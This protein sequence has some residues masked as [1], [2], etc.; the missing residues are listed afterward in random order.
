MYAKSA[1][2]CRLYLLC[3]CRVDAGGSAAVTRCEFLVLE[4]SGE[5][6]QREGWLSLDECQRRRDAERVR[7]GACLIP[8][9]RGVF[10]A[11]SV[12]ENLLLQRPRWIRDGSKVDSAIAVFPELGKRLDERAGSMSGGRQQMRALARAWLSNPSIV[13]WRSPTR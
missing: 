11:L 10:A 5:I 6:A 12:R 3:G 4:V 1:R 2:K 9:G 7:S 8:E 13:H